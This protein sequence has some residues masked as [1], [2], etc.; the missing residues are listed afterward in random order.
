MGRRIRPLISSTS[1]KGPPPAAGSD[2]AELGERLKRFRA[3][4][5]P[6]VARRF[7][8]PTS[9]L[10]TAFA[11]AAHMVA[12]LGVGA[13]L[14]YLLDRW[15][16]TSPW[17]LVVFF[18]L[19]AGAGILNTYRMATGMG[20][21]VGYRP[22]EQNRPAAPADAGSGGHRTRA[23]AGASDRVADANDADE[24]GGDEVE[25]RGGERGGQST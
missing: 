22:A 14:G 10:G 12:G 16:D 11:V 8:Q 6:P 7:D 13:G 5:E 23:D 17:L 25:Q 19:G 21:A 3:E 1:D 15:L 20:M 4:V 18:F 2:L 9:G 24:D